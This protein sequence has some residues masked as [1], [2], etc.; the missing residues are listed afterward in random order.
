MNPDEKEVLMIAYNHYRET[1]D[2]TFQ[3]EFSSDINVKHALSNALD[4]L[5]DDGYIEQ[6]YR[7]IGFCGVKITPTGIRFVENGYKNT[8]CSKPSIHGNN[9]IFVSGSC[10]TVTNNFNKIT[11]D[12]DY[13]DLPEDCKNLIKDF[14][15]EMNNP[16]LSQ[17]RKSSKVKQFLLDISSG[18]MS[19]MASAGLTALLMS[20][21]NQMH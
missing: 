6:V 19:N 3:F 17:E 18:T 1:G 7:A 8:E 20:L 21:F 15:Y 4:A 12:I 16:N 5:R 2:R 13:S 14:L 10:N 11:T 9:N